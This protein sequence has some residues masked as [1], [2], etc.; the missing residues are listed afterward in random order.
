MTTRKQAWMLVVATFAACALA[1]C[2]KVG[3]GAETG[4]GADAGPAPTRIQP[5]RP[6]PVDDPGAVDRLAAALRRPS[7][8]GDEDAVIE[9]LARAGITVLEDDGETP[10]QALAGSPSPFVFSRSAVRA[11][12][13]EVAAGAWRWGAEIDAF[14]R[15]G[16]RVTLSDFVFAYVRVGDTFG[17]RFCRALLPEVLA[18]GAGAARV[19]GL[20]LAFF[21]ADIFPR[22]FWVDSHNKMVDAHARAL[23]SPCAVFDTLFAP[24]RGVLYGSLREN[25]STTMGDAMIR[26]VAVAREISVEAARSALAPLSPAFRMLVPALQ[27]SSLIEP[28]RLRVAGPSGPV[29]HRVAGM[30]TSDVSVQAFVVQGALPPAWLLSCAEDRN[31]PFHA[32]AIEN[33]R[34][35][36]R[37]GDGFDAH[38]TFAGEATSRLDAD[39]GASIGLRLREESA[40]VHASGT[41]KSASVVVACDVDS[42]PF[43]ALGLTLARTMGDATARALASEFGADVFDRLAAVVLSPVAASV[44]IGVTYHE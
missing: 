24:V 29:H 38:A 43:E 10:V 30:S 4:A 19:P 7:S 40:E 13:R 9:A 41:M 8:V 6:A 15:T 35:R 22:L 21:V 32:A 34:L 11:F 17:A 18:G 1:S 14:V 33:A 12:A 27:F 5:A 25:F 3:A 2:G 28:W 37:A 26:S 44:E 23:Q 31:G 42:S 39:G 16:V 20:A 36:W